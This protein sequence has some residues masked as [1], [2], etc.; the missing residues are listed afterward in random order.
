MWGH[1]GSKVVAWPLPVHLPR[2]QCVL[3]AFL[4]LSARLHSTTTTAADPPVR[5]YVAVSDVAFT[6]PDLAG[7][8]RITAT[9]DGCK[10]TCDGTPGCA[11]VV[12]TAATGACV[13]KL[14]LGAPQATLGTAT[15]VVV[16]GA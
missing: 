4:W 6:G 8:V 11:A 16:T 13:I 10:G 5:S 12:Y 1:R 14:G 15:H 3:V 2:V 7:P 9:L